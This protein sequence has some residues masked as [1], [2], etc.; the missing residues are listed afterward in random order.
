MHHH[1]P[2]G[3]RPSPHSE[4]STSTHLDKRTQVQTLNFREGRHSYHVELSGADTATIVVRGRTAWLMFDVIHLWAARDDK[5]LARLR[6]LHERAA[7]LAAPAHERH[8]CHIAPTMPR[9][10]TTSARPVQ[11]IV[12]ARRR[13]VEAVFAGDR[14]EYHEYPG[15][16]SLVISNMHWQGTHRL[17]LTLGG[18]DIAGM[19]RSTSI[20]QIV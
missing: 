2:D 6:I 16:S 13:E 1:P 5:F 7:E 9:R 10:S 3:S 18:R 8:V 20:S 15:T 12:D 14:V 17:S 11:A 19:H 4:E